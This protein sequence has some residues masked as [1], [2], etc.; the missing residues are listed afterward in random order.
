MIPA[1]TF[2][3]VFFFKTAED[4]RGFGG[5]QRH[6]LERMPPL[7]L[8]TEFLRPVRGAVIVCSDSTVAGDGLITV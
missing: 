5:D 4:C 7:F 6:V 1:L 8:P 3:F 2:V